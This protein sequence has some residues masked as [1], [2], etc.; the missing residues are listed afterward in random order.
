MVKNKGAKSDERS[1]TLILLSASLRL[2]S[3]VEKMTALMEIWKSGNVK[4]LEK[5]L[6]DSAYNHPEMP[7]I[8]IRILTERNK[9]MLVKIEDLIKEPGV[10][11]IVVGAAHLIGN[12]GLVHLLTKKGYVL[13]QL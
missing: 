2:S 1:R 7:T 8:R 6:A 13:N 10:D 5:F 9:S 12:D 4:A 11:F 3:E